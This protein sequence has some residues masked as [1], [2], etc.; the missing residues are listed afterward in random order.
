MI[1]S[2]LFPEGLKWLATIQSTAYVHIPHVHAMA[3]AVNVLHI[4]EKAEKCQG[5]SFPKPV[6]RL[7]IGQLRIF[8]KIIK[9]IVKTHP[10]T[11]FVKTASALI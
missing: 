2:I 1:T 3:N 5:A 4:T 9:R 11:V 10:R 6:K 7:M 8:T